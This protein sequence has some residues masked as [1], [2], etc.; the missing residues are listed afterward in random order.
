MKK[1]TYIA[2]ALG[3]HHEQLRAVEDEGGV[4]TAVE[5]DEIV[6]RRHRCRLRR[7]HASTRLLGKSDH[8]ERRGGDYARSPDGMAPVCRV[9]V[10]RA[11][12]DVAIVGAG[13]R[14]HAG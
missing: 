1:K 8:T 14:R 4:A 11:L 3:K 2:C 10:K 12:A 6:G 7:P 13:R 5:Q 9:T